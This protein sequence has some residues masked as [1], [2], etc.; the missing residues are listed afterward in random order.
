MFIFSILC[1]LIFWGA[2]CFA[3]SDMYWKHF[4]K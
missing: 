2:I 1:Q 3:L 4:H